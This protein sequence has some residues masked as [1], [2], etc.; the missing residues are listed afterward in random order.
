MRLDENGRRLGGAVAQVS[1]QA[2]QQWFAEDGHG[3]RSAELSAAT[4]T[5]PTEHV[6]TDGAGDYPPW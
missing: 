5:I 6:P 4:A 2:R 1:R 3:W